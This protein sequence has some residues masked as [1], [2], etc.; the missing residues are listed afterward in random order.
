MRWTLL[1]VLALG[2]G[3]CDRGSRD[4]GG[5]VSTECPAMPADCPATLACEVT[6]TVEDG[7]EV[8]VCGGTACCQ[9]FCDLNGC[10]KCCGPV[11]QAAAT[12][13][14]TPPTTAR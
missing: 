11:G 12:A 5:I 9:S 1:I 14:A 10:G 6:T 8:R 7:A 4:T 3:A 2:L 13:Q